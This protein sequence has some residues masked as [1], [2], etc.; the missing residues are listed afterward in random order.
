MG[1]GVTGRSGNLGTHPWNLHVNVDPCHPAS[2][3]KEDGASGDTGGTP[4]ATCAPKDRGG[5]GACPR[6]GRPPAVGPGRHPPW[7][8]P[9]TIWWHLGPG[10]REGLAGVLRA[11]A[12]SCSEMHGW[13]RGREGARSPFGAEAAST[14]GGWGGVGLSSCLAE[15]GCQPGPSGPT[16]DFQRR[17]NTAGLP[18]RRQPDS[19]L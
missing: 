2:S 12:S 16:P 4:P 8:A 17:K 3:M 13:G 1:T 10:R 6:P 9:A 19:G 5:A 14:P 11:A 18:G 7:A 15:T